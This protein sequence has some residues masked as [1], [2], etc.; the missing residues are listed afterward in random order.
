MY[1]FGFTGNKVNEGFYYA[2]ANQVIFTMFILTLDRLASIFF[3][4]KYK[5]YV[6]KRFLFR[7]IVASWVMSG[8]LGALSVPVLSFVTLVSMVTASVYI[9]IAIASYALIIVK[10]RMH[11]NSV[12]VNSSAGVKP[13]TFLVPGLIIFTFIVSYV[14]VFL[15]KYVIDRKA[16]MTYGDFIVH[17][18][19]NIVKGIGFSTDPLIYIFLTKRYRGMVLSV[20]LRNN[21]PPELSTRSQP[22]ETIQLPAIVD[23]SAIQGVTN[24]SYET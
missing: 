19:I 11:S 8:I 13:K 12:V 18:S 15:V 7:T 3:L 9:L 24:P 17:E 5:S 1:D 10:I 6:T 20:F 14:I 23:N 22:D 4:L 2:L 16:S 21:T